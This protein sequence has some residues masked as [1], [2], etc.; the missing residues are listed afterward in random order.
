MIVTEPNNPACDFIAHPIPN[1][2]TLDDKKTEI[3]KKIPEKQLRSLFSDY[4]DQQHALFEQP[5]AHIIHAIQWARAKPGMCITETLAGTVRMASDR[6]PSDLSE[7][8]AQR[9]KEQRTQIIDHMLSWFPYVFIEGAAGTGK[10]SF[11]KEYTQN[12]QRFS[13][14][15]IEQWAMS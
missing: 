14:N 5:Y 3:F 1:T 8:T 13:Q 7:Q 6:D 4:S 2:I 11:I 10:S 15:Q 12:K 9:F